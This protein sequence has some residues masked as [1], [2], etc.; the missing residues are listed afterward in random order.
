MEKVTV[1]KVGGA[2][3][4]NSEQ[5]AQLLKDFAASSR[6]YCSGTVGSVLPA[7]LH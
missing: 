4:E 1:V 2:I 7:F 5:L 6:L 3:V